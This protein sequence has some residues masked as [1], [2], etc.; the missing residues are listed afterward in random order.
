MIII[1]ATCKSFAGGESLK[2]LRIISSSR[3]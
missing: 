2:R 3:S 1:E